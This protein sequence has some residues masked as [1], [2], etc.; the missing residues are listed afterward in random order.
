MSDKVSNIQ[1]DRQEPKDTPTP[2]KKQ[3]PTTEIWKKGG[4]QS[5]ADALSRDKSSVRAPVTPGK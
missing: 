3:E 2:L 5:P 1:A 4:D